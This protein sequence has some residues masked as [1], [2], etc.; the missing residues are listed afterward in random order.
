MCTVISMHHMSFPSGLFNAHAA[1][2]LLQLVV[3]IHADS[4][5]IFVLFDLLAHNAHTTMSLRVTCTTA[6]QR[7][8]RID[9]TTR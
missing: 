4:S 8:K 3:I 1:L 7:R 9:E 6:L 5:C 2:T